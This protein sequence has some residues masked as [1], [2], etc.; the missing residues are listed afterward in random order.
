MA[1]EHTLCLGG[2]RCELPPRGRVGGRFYEVNRDG[3]QSDWGQVRVWEPPRRVVFSFNPGR[4]PDTAEQVEVTFQP[5][6]GGTR[7][8]LTHSE[9]ELFGPR[10]R[11]LRD[12]YDHGW[13]TVLNRFISY[14]DSGA[15][16]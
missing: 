9:W 4:S 1:P 16:R 13:N 15:S 7:V 2:R 5:D 10:A 11:E 6:G 8:T 3:L 14:A 12:N